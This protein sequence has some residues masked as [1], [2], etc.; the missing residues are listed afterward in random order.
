MD[1]KPKILQL[2]ID[3]PCFKAILSGEQKIEHRFVYPHNARRYVIE[4]DTTDEN[5]EIVTEVKPV[6][7]DALRLINGRRHDAPHMT[8]AVEKAEFVV[9]TDENGE[10]MTFVENGIE[11][12]VCQVWYYLGKILSTEHTEQLSS[13]SKEVTPKF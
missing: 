6:H 12:Y 8:I 9:L 13:N 3:R 4:T 7:Y 2:Q 1:K 11:Y 5:G 10:D